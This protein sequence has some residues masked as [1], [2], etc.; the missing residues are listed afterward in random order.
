VFQENYYYLKEKVE[1]PAYKAENI[2]VGI[3]YADHVAL[4]IRK[5]W[6]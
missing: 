4:S 3:S 2:A 5:S 1:A 6:Q